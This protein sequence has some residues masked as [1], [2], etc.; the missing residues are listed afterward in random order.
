MRQMLHKSLLPCLLLICAARPLA[1]QTAP[2]Q[3]VAAD[4]AR[5]SGGV[6]DYIREKKPGWKHET[7]PPATPPGGTPS[8]YVVIHFWSSE[9]CL[10]AELKIDGVGSGPQPVPCRVKLAID[11]SPTAA[12]ARARLSNFARDQFGE[13]L[14]PVEVGDKGYVWQGSSV[15]FIKGKFT[16]WLSGGADLRVGDFSINR[17]FIEGLAKEIAGSVSAQ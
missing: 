16:F 1:A 11:Q 12:D 4:L 14:T 5:A 17:G 10:T 3:T 6:E 7:V 9:K 13:S 2:P 8:P 15:V